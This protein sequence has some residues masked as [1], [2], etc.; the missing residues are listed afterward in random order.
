MHLLHISLTFMIFSALTHWSTS[1]GYSQA[2]HIVPFSTLAEN[3]AVT[4]GTQ[5]FAVL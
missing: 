5:I 2:L 3:T 1:Q 4:V